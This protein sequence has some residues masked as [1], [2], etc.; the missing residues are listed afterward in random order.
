[1]KT[2][3]K[4]EFAVMGVNSDGTSRTLS[5]RFGNAVDAQKYIGEYISYTVRIPDAFTPFDEYKI[6]KR[7][8]ITTYEEWEE[9]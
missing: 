9:V 1:M 7:N 3:T 8:V 6:V 4:T 2:K 5:K